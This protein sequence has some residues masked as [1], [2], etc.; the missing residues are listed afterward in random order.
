[1]SFV[2]LHCHT[3][4]SI[5]DATL[6][7]AEMAKFAAAQAM[8][9]IAI[10]DHDNLHGAVAFA[11]AC[12]KHSV[13]PIFGCCLAIASRPAGEHVRRAH[14]LTL[15]AETNEGYQNLIYLI[16]KAN[17][18]APANSMARID[19]QLLKDHSA[20]LIGLSGD[21]SSEICNALLRGELD[22]AYRAAERYRS[23][24]A[25]GAFYLEVQRSGLAEHDTV[26]P[27]LIA[28]G[29][30]LGI[31]CVATN[32]VHYL[33]PDDARAHEV[34]VCIGL[35]LQCRP[36]DQA[37]PTTALDLASADDMR[38]RFA[39][40]PQLC[41]ATIEIAERCNVKLDLGQTLLPRFPVPDDTTEAAFFAELSRQGLQRRFSEFSE[42]GKAI[43]EQV[44][45]T[46]LEREI[47]VIAS[48]DFPGY[49]LIVQD[50]INWAKE[51]NIAV[52]PGRGSGAGS[53]VAYAL[54]ITDIDPL[55]YNLLFE[56][57]LNPERVSMPDFDI[58]FCVDR[59]GEVIRY[60][61]QRYGT[62][63]VGQIATFGTLK[64]K[65]AVRDVGRVQ[66]VP[67]TDVDRLSKLIDVALTGADDKHQSVANAIENDAVLR[68]EMAQSPH[69]DK[70][71]RTAQMLEGAVRNV[72]MH[73]AGV[74]IG[75]GPL[76][77]HVPVGKGQGGENVTQF[78]KYDVEKAGLVKFDF[79]GLKNLTMIQHCVQIINAA[80]PKGAPAF[81][82]AKVRLDDAKAFAIV[83]KGDTA[84][85]FQC[86]SSG[87]TAMMVGLKPSVFEDLIA[88]GALYRPGPLGMKMDARYI[89]RKHG[90]EEVVY[91]HP[92]L[93]EVLHETYGVIVYQEQVM[94][95]SQILAGFTLGQAD[96]LRRAM[97][98]K[99]LE[100]MQK[101]GQIFRDGAVANGV[102]PQVA[103]DVF[104]MMEKFAE[105]GFN[106]SHSAAYGLITYHTAYLK[107]NY[108]VEFFAALLTA[109]QSDTDKVVAYI[110]QSRQAGIRVMPPDVNESG[111]SF[112]VVDGKIRFGLGA[113][114]GLGEGAIE[115]LLQARQ[116]GS[117][118]SLYD[119][120]ARAD[121]R[122]VNKKAL[123]VLI[124][125]GAC[126]S[127]G[128]PRDVLW[129][130]VGRA[131]QRAQDEQKERESAQT[132]LFGMLGASPGAQRPLTYVGVDIPW[133]QREM[134]ANE[135]EVLGFYVSGHPL[136]RYANEL[137]RL[138]V[139]S[140]ATIKDPDFL[141]TI[142][143]YSRGNQDPNAPAPP[144]RTK[145]HVAAIVVQYKERPLNDGR[146]MGIA[147]LEDRSGQAEALCFDDKGQWK[148]LLTAD[149]PLWLQLQVGEDRREPG[150][151]ALRLES[152]VALEDKVLEK[153]EQLLLRLR[154]NQ[155]DPKTLAELGTILA[156]HRGTA[157]IK[158][159]LLLADRGEVVLACGD[160]WRVKADDALIG[161]LERLLGREAARIG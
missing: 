110:Q 14:H 147:L 75:R 73:A 152:A 22:D 19:W 77:T 115:I 21:L 36:E 8:P 156:A 15:L 155:C 55:P 54:R 129:A 47:G 69:I 98:K 51:Q 91:P 109:D 83:G 121:S 122:K 150:K 24:F 101:W 26:A 120:V 64:A 25:P 41:D 148:A 63:R 146:R 92:K 84:G 103:T 108:P 157:R 158:A 137:Q 144:K 42:I 96:N 87:F 34:L 23:W 1:M 13:K 102:E 30:Q 78:D 74:V 135:K 48:M 145:V 39:Q 20:G 45:V 139:R 27:Q 40:W 72:G 82:L 149:A 116:T 28:L 44:Y 29:Q 16:S 161:K 130:N 9:A 95:V 106:K 80:L 128:Q 68:N 151:V 33:R 111:R 11:E 105:Y 71:L 60:V 76:W 61:A 88:A 37:L 57:F 35:G 94:Q 59:R 5:A 124:K 46:R 89:E 100:E 79:L 70:L 53:L 65:G 31:P 17:L 66:G 85:I 52:G 56:R 136:D 118:T 81:D 132:S 119:L 99:K 123:E 67:L 140:L 126:D 4:Y 10:T 127:L 134:L 117:F 154:D 3:Q 159:H 32:D 107:A 49:F 6:R 153:S 138:D 141:K 97:G 112:S 43:D 133:T 86:E 38:R 160:K 131:V 62:E 113:I 93:A 12:K 90:R 142:P 114:R 125:S 104:E 143:S 58:D 7:V 50:F 2:H 18:L